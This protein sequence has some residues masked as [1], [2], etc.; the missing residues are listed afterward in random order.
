[1]R[2][3][4]QKHIDIF[5]EYLIEEEKS[6]L[7]VEKHIRDITVFKNWCNNVQI[8]KNLVVEYKR[9]LINNYAP[10]SVNSVLSSLNSFLCLIIGM[11]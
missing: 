8:S 10:A 4:Q 5:K 7:T 1:M 2:V 11:I 6:D 9:K 3:I